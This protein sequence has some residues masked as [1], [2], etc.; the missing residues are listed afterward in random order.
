MH[1]SLLSKYALF[2]KKLNK[3]GGQINETNKTTATYRR[4]SIIQ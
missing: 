1:I 4:K 2:D 3:M